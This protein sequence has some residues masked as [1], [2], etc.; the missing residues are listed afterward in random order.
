MSEKAQKR[1]HTPKLDA[2]LLEQYQKNPRAFRVR[3]TW[4]LVVGI[5]F[6]AFAALISFL[7]IKVMGPAYGGDAMLLMAATAGL[8]AIA[9]LDDARWRMKLAA[10][11]APAAQ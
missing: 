11:S 8:I 4:N 10:P 9:I 1:S 3:T 6:L 5:I 2:E 7:A